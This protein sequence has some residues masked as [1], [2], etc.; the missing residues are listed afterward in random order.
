MTGRRPTVNSRKPGPRGA[1]RRPANKS[2]GYSFTADPDSWTDLSPP[3][4]WLTPGNDS[5]ITKLRSEGC[6]SIPS[7]APR[8]K[9]LKQYFF[10]IHPM[11]PL[12][13]ESTVR[14][15]SNVGTL[16]SAAHADDLTLLLLLQALLLATSIVS[17]HHLACL[18]P[19]RAYVT[20]LVCFSGK[21]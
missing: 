7:A 1:S 8:A 2:S 19:L 14:Q 9:F 18:L 13:D 10:H 5:A 11:L 20:T 16:E 17:F 12:L 4:P 15:L 21:A 3:A 6:F